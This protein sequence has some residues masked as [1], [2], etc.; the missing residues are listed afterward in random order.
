VVVLEA[1]MGIRGVVRKKRRLYWVNNTRIHLDEV[2]GLGS[3]MELEV[4][5]STGQRTEEG[6]AT[7]TALMKRLGIEIADL[8]KGA[9][10]D[11]LELT[12]KDS[13]SNE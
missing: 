11:L 2:E 3:F 13:K 9:Y 7:A 4:M 8:V 10:I 12:E 1:A 5:L 6:E